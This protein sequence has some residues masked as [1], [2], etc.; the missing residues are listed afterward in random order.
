MPGIESTS[1]NGFN[2]LDALRNLASSRSNQSQQTPTQSQ[3]L[4]Q[5]TGDGVNLTSQPAPQ[6]SF[7]QFFI[8]AFSYFLGG[9]FGLFGQ[10]NQ[11][12]PG[13]STQ[14]PTSGTTTQQP[15]S[16][17]TTTQQPT[18]GTSSTSN[19]SPVQ[20]TTGGSQSSTISELTAAK[21]DPKEIKENAAN[22]P[23]T[24][25]LEASNPNGIAQRNTQYIIGTEGEDNQISASSS[26]RNLRI[27][28][29]SANTDNTNYG[30]GDNLVEIPYGAQNTTVQTW[31]VNG[32]T[33]T[34]NID[35]GARD[36]QVLLRK[37]PDEDFQ[38]Q[39]VINS[40][41]PSTSVLLEEINLS[42]AEI[43]RDSDGSLMIKSGDIE[44][45]INGQIE[46]LYSEAE[47]RFYS[48]S[49]LQGRVR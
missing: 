39:F 34:I 3:Q 13:T 26:S 5:Q 22:N 48:L 31:G 30:Q 27:D 17:T 6:N 43:T 15:T 14:Q 20:P 29:L 35:Q 11:G 44:I 7:A 10:Q 19:T 33:N 47:N 37:V 9:L 38:G 18:S 46:G 16:G 36:T 24:I 1:G 12:T 42:Q 23:N 2:F 49:E 40:Q 45:T 28:P 8:Q 41:D 25:S 32:I 21:F 4:N